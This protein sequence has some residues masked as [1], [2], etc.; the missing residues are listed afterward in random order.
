M[1]IN[2]AQRQTRLPNFRVGRGELLRA[3]HAGSPVSSSAAVN[4][5]VSL[6]DD[7]AQLATLSFHMAEGGRQAVLNGSKAFRVHTQP[8]AEAL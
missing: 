6:S 3:V 4:H 1:V 5:D 8:A 7:A 2:S